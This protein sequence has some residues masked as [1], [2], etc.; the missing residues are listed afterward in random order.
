MLIFDTPITG[1]MT[2]QMGKGAHRGRLRFKSNE[3][4]EELHGIE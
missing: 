4:R 2:A 3:L 1:Q